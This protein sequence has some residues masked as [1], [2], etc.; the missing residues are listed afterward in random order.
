VNKAAPLGGFFAFKHLSTPTLSGSSRNQ[1]R[2][3][4]SFP[5][6]TTSS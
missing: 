5:T 2:T 3:R 4:R 6:S 1:L